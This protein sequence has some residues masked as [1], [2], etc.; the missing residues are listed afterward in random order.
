VIELRAERLL[1]RQWC[2]TDLEPFA[3]L[4]ADPEVMRHLPAALG[5]A[6]SGG[7]AGRLRETIADRGGA[8]GPSKSSSV[9][10]SSASSGCPR[11]GS[12]PLHACDRG[13]LRLAR[14]HWGRG[15]ATEAA[16]AALTFG[17]QQL[18][19]GRSS[20]FTT[21]G[22]VRSRW[23]MERLGMTHEVADDFDHPLLAPDDPLRPHV[24]YRL[25][26]ASPAGERLLAADRRTSGCPVQ[27]CARTALLWVP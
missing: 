26:R 6:D 18:G 14:Q 2:E 9:R 13:R 3:G 8:S 21:V 25:R 7:F 20:P 4:N 16:R 27:P 22:N 17:F 1:L 11:R 15:H 10:R 23:V 19:L 5:R 24:L 12:G